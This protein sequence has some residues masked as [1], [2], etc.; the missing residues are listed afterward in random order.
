MNLKFRDTNLREKKNATYMIIVVMAML[1]RGKQQSVRKVCHCLLQ[2]KGK[3]KVQ[4][5]SA[6][7]PKTYIT[8]KIT[9]FL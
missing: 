8:M 1:D 5:K 3:Q 9:L 6:S 2:N 4:G 7:K